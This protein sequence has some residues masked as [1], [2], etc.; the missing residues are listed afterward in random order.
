M[1]GPAG[2]LPLSTGRG[3]REA[4]AIVYQELLNP[5]H[6]Q[7]Y[8]GRAYWGLFPFAAL[9]VPVLTAGLFVAWE[10]VVHLT[11]L[12]RTTGEFWSV[13]RP[14]LLGLGW[15]HVILIFITIFS[16]YAVW[17]E[18]KV[19][20]H[21]QCRTGPMEV[22][23]IQGSIFLWK[24]FN[25][26]L[27]PKSWSPHGWLQT[28]ADGLKLM[29]KEDLIPK[30]ADRWIFI[31]APIVAFTGV[32][33]SFLVIPFHGVLSSFIPADLDTGVFFFAAV[34]SIEAIGVIMAG[35]ASNNKWALFGAMRAATQVVSYELPIGLAFLTAV[36]AAGSLRVSDIVAAQGPDYGMLAW[37]VFR[38]PFLL[39]AFVIY[40]I[41]S[42]AEC[43]RAPF[44][45]PEAESELI[46]GFHTE[47]SSMRFS[48]FFLAEY[49]AMYV[50]AAFAAVLF[51]GGW[52]T[53]IAP[54]DHFLAD[55]AK[56]DGLL[57][58]LAAV[59]IGVFAVVGKSMILVFFQMAAR[60]T[61][62]RARLDQVMYLCLKVFLPFGLLTLVGG[63]AWELWLEGG[64]PKAL[65]G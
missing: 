49:A 19:S 40:F 16:M 15:V 9:F 7:T 34:T 45:L 58:R 11:G 37:F 2:S 41:S 12:T 50:V 17:M 18:R 65:L 24:R 53:G 27:W 4:T 1:T 28:L 54:V 35:W 31:L 21:M 22:G 38:S 29:A 32:F 60:W 64:W 52:W 56:S 13:A 62:P 6:A 43:K 47:Y 48:I 59:G 25:F 3:S 42:L 20:A 33:I 39:L 61:Y 5:H 51:L 8:T 63:T 55:A 23:R 30:D 57:P 26:R 36:V 46:S 44:D 14:L 10:A